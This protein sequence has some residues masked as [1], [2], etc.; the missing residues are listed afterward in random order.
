VVNEELER[1]FYGTAPVDIA[2]QAA[3]EKAN[4]EL[5]KDQE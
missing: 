3:I 5:A 4:A 2:I 1:A